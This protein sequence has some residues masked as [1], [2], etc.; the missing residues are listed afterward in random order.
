MATEAT[1]SDKS[2]GVGL[3]L[4]VIALLGAAVMFAGPGQELKAWGFA[5]AVGAAG[6]AIVFLHLFE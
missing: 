5:G 1:Q 6:L 4:S 3:A 2:I